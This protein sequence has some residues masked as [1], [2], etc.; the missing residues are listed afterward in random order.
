[1]RPDGHASRA[2]DLDLRFD[3]PPDDGQIAAAAGGT[4]ARMAKSVEELDQALT[5]AFRAV[6]GGERAAVVDVWL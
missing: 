2:N 6:R 1:M 3:P 4:L 5:D